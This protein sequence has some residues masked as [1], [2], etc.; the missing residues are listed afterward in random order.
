MVANMHTIVDTLDE[1]HAN[2]P[3]DHLVNEKLESLRKMPMSRKKD[4]SP[5]E[6]QPSTR[7][8]L[9]FLTLAVMTLM[10]ALDGTSL[11]VALP[12]NWRMTPRIVM[13]T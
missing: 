11:S 2:L 8:Y 10:A 1:R 7:L 9:A 13:G 3:L 12:V 4:P 5:S 6:F